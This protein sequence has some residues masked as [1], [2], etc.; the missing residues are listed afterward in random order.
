MLGLRH[1]ALNVADIQK[2]TDFYVQ[3]IEMK[4][5]WQPDPKNVY[6]TTGS[7]NL[8][9]HE[10]ESVVQGVTSMDHFGFVVQT[11]EEVDEWAEKIKKAGIPFAK[12]VKTHRDGARSFYFR[13]PEEN[14]IQIIYHPPISSQ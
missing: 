4:I 7:D 9:L 12:E 10:V 6:L 14:L 13:D 8:A 2:M 5:E 3:V 1:L 11:A